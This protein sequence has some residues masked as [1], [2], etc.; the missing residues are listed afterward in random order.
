MGCIRD[1][2]IARLRRS[3]SIRMIASSVGVRKRAIIANGGIYVG[4]KEDSQE[5]WELYDAQTRWR[6][7]AQYR[8]EIFYEGT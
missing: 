5:G 7:L 6:I 8:E 2:H 1:S 4:E 3:E